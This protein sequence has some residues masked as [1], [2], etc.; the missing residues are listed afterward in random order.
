MS[1]S[2]KRGFSI[3]IFLP[4]GTPDGLRVVEK[5]NWT[6]QCIVC[7]RV[8]LSEA[9]NR[10]EFG[11]TGIYILVG[12]AAEGDL[13]S[14]YIGEGDPVRPRLE[15]HHAKKDFWTSLM[16]FTSKDQNLNKAHVQYLEAHLI[17]LAND[18]KR[19]ILDNGNMPQLPSLSEA[20]CSE[21]DAFLD[22]MLLIY[23]LLGLGV[24][25]RPSSPPVASRI[26]EM[27]TKRIVA[28]G[29]E[30]A[31]G[32]VVLKGSQAV[33]ETVPSIHQYMLTL[34]KALV[35]KEILSEKDGLFILTQD[36][37]FDSPSTAAGVMLGRT[38]N[39][40]IEWKDE[41]GKTLREIQTAGVS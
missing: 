24:F 17:R 30:S 9:K 21:M 23:P 35:A 5:S 3:R 13:P 10:Q 16:L 41:Q 34:R 26:L 31:D 7:P 1:V 29:Y 18:A 32:F 2:S 8:Q 22:E 25:E 28:K 33:I 38:A 11:K 6:G 39:G 37:R 20:D 27:K 40:R 36:Y 19:C 12:P 14:I 4:D 15:Q